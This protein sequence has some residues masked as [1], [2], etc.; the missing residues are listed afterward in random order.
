MEKKAKTSFTTLKQSMRLLELGVPVD[1]ADCYICL[2]GMTIN[3]IPEDSPKYSEYCRDL[4]Y[5]RPCWS[6]YRLMEIHD[7]CVE[8]LDTQY[9]WAMTGDYDYIDYIISRF[10]D[11]VMNFS[12]WE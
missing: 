11:E 7:I 8:D 1:S 3:I 2:N 5:L 12:K 6:V 9:G 10:E 4:T